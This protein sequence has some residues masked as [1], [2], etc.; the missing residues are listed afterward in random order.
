MGEQSTE[1]KNI[2]ARLGRVE[3]ENRR[4]R[5]GGLGVLVLAGVVLLMG[6]AHP[7]RTIEAEKFVLK[8]ASGRIRAR[9]EMELV[10]RPTLTLLDARGFP[11]VSLAA[12]ENPLLTLCK[13]HCEKQAQL[14]ISKDLVG[15]ALYEGGE[16]WNPMAGEQGKLNGLRAGFGVIKGIPG[17]NLFGTNLNEQA[18]LDLE[19]GPRLLLSSPDGMLSFEKTSFEL[20]DMQGFRTMIGSTELETPRTGETHKTSAASIVL[21]GKDGKALWSAP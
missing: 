14:V 5:Q 17:L 18:S 2:L 15:L 19:K 10:D 8:D 12:G 6:Q 9:L 21:F 4:L 7:N 11:L 20:S 3:R 16:G 1:L 13:G